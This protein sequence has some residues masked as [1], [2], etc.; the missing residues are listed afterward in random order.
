MG[1]SRWMNLRGGSW[2]EGDV[3][4]LWG[5]PRNAAQDQQDQGG[6]NRKPG[7]IQ[8]PVSLLPGTQKSGAKQKGGA[9][10]RGSRSLRRG[11]LERTIIDASRCY[12]FRV[13]QAR[14]GQ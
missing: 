11:D 12:S 3:R 14:K 9:L 6:E 1:T 8:L 4:P 13:A 2:P 5:D 10:C 7:R